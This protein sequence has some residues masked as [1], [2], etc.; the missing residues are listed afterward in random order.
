[1]NLLVIVVAFGFIAISRS[2][3][4]ASGKAPAPKPMTK[5]DRWTLYAIILFC[6]SC[7][8]AGVI[9]DMIAAGMLDFDF[10]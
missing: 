1:M 10:L 7:Y 5:K 6:V 3:L 8:I 4:V 2:I 9:F